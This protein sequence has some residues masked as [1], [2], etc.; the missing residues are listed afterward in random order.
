MKKSILLIALLALVVLS[1]APVQAGNITITMS[2]PGGIAIRDIVVYFPNGTMYGYY[3]S[4]SV[5]DLDT[6]S[7]YLFALKPLKTNA[8][9]DPQDAM[10]DGFDYVTTNWIPLVLVVTLIAILLFRRG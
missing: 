9:E 8:L 7:S 5:I 4:S 10:Q 2:N 3:N 1:L 6:N